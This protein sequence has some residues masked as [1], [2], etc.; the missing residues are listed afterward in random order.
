[1]KLLGDDVKAHVEEQTRKIG[2]L[3]DKH[4]TT[5]KRVKNLV[6]VNT[7]YKKSRKP[8]LHNAILHVHAERFNKGKCLMHTDSTT[9][10]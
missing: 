9:P 3:A 4:N 7:H 2:E 5:V 10:H 6:G 1:M 8:T